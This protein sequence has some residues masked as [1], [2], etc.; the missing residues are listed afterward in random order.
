MYA[1]V[2]ANSFYC[3]VERSFNPALE[4]KPIVVLSNRD[5]NI[6]A[7]NAEAKALGI[8][9]GAFF[10]EKKELITTH[11]VAVFSSNY[12]LYGDIS[13]RLMSCLAKFVEDIEVYS[14]DEAFLLVDDS[15]NQYYPSYQ[16]LGE[17]IR[18]KIKQWLRL[19]ISIG[20]GPTKTLAK[21]ANRLAKLNPALA[22]VCVLDTPDKISAALETYPIDDIWGVG[23]RS[24]VK[25]KRFGIRTAA[26][27]STVPIDWI[28][29]KMTV[30]GVRLVYELQG[31]AC[32]LL[33]VN[34]PAKKSLCT[35]PGFGKVTPS[36]EQLED[37]L[38]FHLSR[39]CEKLRRQE[40]MAGCL[41]VYLRTDPN[42]KTPGNGLPSKQ[43]SNARTV[44]LPHPT[45]STA[46]LLQY[47]SAALQEVFVYGYH[48]LRVGVMLTDLVPANHRQKGIF[49][50][51][52]N[53]QA[54]QLAR[55]VDKINHRYGRDKLRLASQLGN[56][57]WPMKPQFLSPR[58][59]TQWEDILV[60]K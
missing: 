42:R 12:P 28:R 13:A 56:P 58:Y 24:A 25:L 35:E 30:N 43:F 41:T 8:K 23:H 9:M 32:K 11:N 36:L 5:G 57:D 7:R 10:F 50:D 2:D 17:T 44:R 45:S 49:V 34:T 4:G 29:E 31:K 55:V 48:Y 21:M 39:L 54:L 60:A 40:S 16:G 26:Q 22:G 18:A 37:A 38:A 27:L 51:G 52:P 14:I 3:S 33:E 1:L 15:Y 59:T 53:E 47:A 6:I 20:F 46:E 19:P